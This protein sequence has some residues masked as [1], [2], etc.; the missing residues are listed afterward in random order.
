MSMPSSTKPT[1][2][3]VTPTLRSYVA[4]FVLSILLTLEAYVLV[5]RHAVASPILVAAVAGLALVQFIVQLLFF[6]HLGRETKP[7]WKFYVF[8][9]TVLLVAVLVIGSIWIMSNLGYHTPSPSEVDH[10]L[11]IQS[12][13]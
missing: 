13:L 6:L 9:Y 5:V 1:P 7:R 2:P 11:K 12:G 3:V 10:Y 4:G 8:L